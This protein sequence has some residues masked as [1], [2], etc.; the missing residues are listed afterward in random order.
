MMEAVGSS[1]ISANICKTTWH[2]IPED[3]HLHIHHHENLKDHLIGKHSSAVENFS[4]STA[5]CTDIL[6]LLES[7]HI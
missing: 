6:T 3:S 1:K 7:K 5:T 4:M 2:N